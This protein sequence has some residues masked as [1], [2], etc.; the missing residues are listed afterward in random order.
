MISLFT[1]NSKIWVPMKS[2]KI[3]YFF[4]KKIYHKNRHRKQNRCSTVPARWNLDL[5]RC[6]CNDMRGCAGWSVPLL[7]IYHK[8]RLSHDVAHFQINTSYLRRIRREGVCCIQIYGKK[9]KTKKNNCW[10][11]IVN[12]LEF[13]SCGF[14]CCSQENK[15]CTFNQSCVLRWGLFKKEEYEFWLYKHSRFMWQWIE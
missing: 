12:R 3:V 5:N 1:H 6:T 2:R 14:R 4:I 13:F 9:K 7:C 10:F 11:T 8:N 15:F